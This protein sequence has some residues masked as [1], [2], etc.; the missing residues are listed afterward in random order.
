[1]ITQPAI[2]QQ[3]EV[4]VVKLKGQRHAQPETPGT[5]SVNSPAAGG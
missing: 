2:A 4:D 5:T 3:P 1:M